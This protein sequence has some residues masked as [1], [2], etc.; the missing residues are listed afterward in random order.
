M[1]AMDKRIQIR[2]NAIDTMEYENNINQ[3][4]SFIDCDDK[5]SNQINGN[6]NT[7]V[8]P[9]KLFNTETYN[10]NS[11]LTSSTITSSCNAREKLNSSITLIT[12]TTNNSR[13]SGSSRIAAVEMYIM[14]ENNTNIESEVSEMNLTFTPSL[15]QVFFL[16]IM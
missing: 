3:T 5:K 4:I 16:Y 13:V 2:N 1:V 7:S 15:S 12:S 9:F 6:M 10:N 14:H 8:S 11:N